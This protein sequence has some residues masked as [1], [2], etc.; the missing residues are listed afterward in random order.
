MDYWCMIQYWL[1][2]KTKGKKTFLKDQTHRDTVWCHLYEFPKVGK[3]IEI[4]SRLV[5]VSVVGGD[6]RRN[7]SDC[8]WAWAFSLGWCKYSKIVVMVI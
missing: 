3:S 5:V 7:G 2:L 6:L 4:E 8:K 1:T